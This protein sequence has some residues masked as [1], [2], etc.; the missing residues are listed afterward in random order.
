MYEILEKNVIKIK[1][2][3]IIKSVKKI[4]INLKIRHMFVKKNHQCY[5]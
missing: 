2:K 5:N 4:I 3:K 1:N